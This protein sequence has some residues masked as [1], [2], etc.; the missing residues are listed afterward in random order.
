M[1]NRSNRAIDATYV[2]RTFNDIVYRANLDFERVSPFLALETNSKKKREKWKKR[3]ETEKEVDIN[4]DRINLLS[5]PAQPAPQ[6]YKCQIVAR[7]SSYSGRVH[8]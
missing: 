5:P 4:I 2:L 7:P 8:D 6:N 3:S 1:T